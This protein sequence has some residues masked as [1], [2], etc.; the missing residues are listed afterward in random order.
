MLL[1]FFYINGLFRRRLQAEITLTLVGRADH[2]K[3][4]RL[5][6][7]QTHDRHDKFH[8]TRSVFLSVDLYNSEFQ[9]AGGVI[10]GPG[11][12]DCQLA[13]SYRRTQVAAIGSQLVDAVDGSKD[14]PIGQS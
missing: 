11:P 4:H 14:R 5:I 13:S 1:P 12:D 2:A 8:Y 3:L 7:L 9:P 6:R 10:T